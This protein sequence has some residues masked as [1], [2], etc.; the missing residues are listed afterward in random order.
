MA[1]NF[2]AGRAL[3]VKLGN[4]EKGSLTRNRI[5]DEG[6]F[7]DCCHHEF[8]R[9]AQDFFFVNGSNLFFYPF[10]GL[11]GSAEIQQPC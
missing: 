10:V 6:F 1:L 3:H 7:V 8:I 5:T 9:H 4:E 11:G 2:D